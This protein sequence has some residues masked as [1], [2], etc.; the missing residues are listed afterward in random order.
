MDKECNMAIVDETMV[1]T[2][3][4]NLDRIEQNKGVQIIYA[5][6][7]GSRAW[8]FASR[9]SDY[10]VRFV[11][12]H[13]VDWYLSIRERRDVI[14]CPISG[15]LDIAGWDLR[16]A[17]GLFRKS[18]PPLLE[19]LSSPVVYRD[20]FRVAEQLRTLMKDHFSPKSCLYHYVHS[21]YR[22][23]RECQR[24][25]TPKI[26]KYCYMLRPILACMWIEKHNSM[27]PVEISRLFADVSLAP[28]LTAAIDG[29]I[30]SKLAGIETETG[31]QIPLLNDFFAEKLAY[32]EQLAKT[33]APIDIDIRMLDDLFRETLHKVWST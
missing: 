26:K 2:I 31:P 22:R 23:F 20:N 7:S 21:A 3:V 16:K 33:M 17:L 8:G 19:W 15:D 9:D 14:E 4:D 13:P 30:A 27:P 5:V 25:E 10:D 28:E 29:L 6:E 32:F 18:N 24:T 1:A 12:I 11:Y